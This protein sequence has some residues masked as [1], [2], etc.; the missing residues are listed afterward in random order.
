MQS[1]VQEW[2]H[3]VREYTMFAPVQLL[4]IWR[5]ER[6]SDQGELGSSVTVDIGRVYYTGVDLL[7]I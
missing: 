7:L 5:E 6:P 1:N 3:S 2:T 4:R